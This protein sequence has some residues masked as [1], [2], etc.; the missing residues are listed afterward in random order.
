MEAAGQLVP[1]IAEA[2]CAPLPPLTPELGGR[3]RLEN[4]SLNPEGMPVWAGYGVLTF[5]PYQGGCP[6]C[7]LRSACPKRNAGPRAGQPA[8][9]AGNGR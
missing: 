4:V 2:G 1:E 3:L 6:V 5:Y 8:R 7:E 9:P